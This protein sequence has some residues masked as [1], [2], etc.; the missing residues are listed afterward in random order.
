MGLLSPW[1]GKRDG[2]LRFQGGQGTFRAKWENRSLLG[3]L[4]ADEGECDTDM[5]GGLVYRGSGKTSQVSIVFY[6]L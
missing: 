5:E 3:E 2:S 6:R 1:G 4:R